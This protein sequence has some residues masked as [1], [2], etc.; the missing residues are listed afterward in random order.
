V[1]RKTKQ[2]QKQTNKQKEKKKKNKKTVNINRNHTPQILLE[3]ITDKNNKY[4]ILGYL[5]TR[6]PFGVKDS[7]ILW[8]YTNIWG[9]LNVSFSLHKFVS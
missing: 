3:T 2:K 5:L 6:I 7:F 9:V 8:I 4:S 1:R